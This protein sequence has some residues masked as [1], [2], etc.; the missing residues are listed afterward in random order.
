MAAINI[1]ASL[2]YDSSYTSKLVVRQSPNSSSSVIGSIDPGTSGIS[3]T[4]VDGLWYYVPDYGGWVYSSYLETEADITMVEKP[5]QQYTE[6][7]ANNILQS[8]ITSQETSQDEVSNLI[9]TSLEGIY[10]IPYQFMSSVDRKV[11]GTKLGTIYS[12][13]IVSR[14][15]LLLLS[16]G[17]VNFMRDYKSKNAAAQALQKL[18]ENSPLD[19]ANMLDSHGRYYTFDFDYVNYYKYVNAMC[20]SGAYFLNLQDTQVKIGGK[21]VKLKNADWGEAG[22]NAFKSI[23]SKREY[24]AFYVDSA[25]SVNEGFNNSTTE[26][27]LVSKIN[28][29]SDVG[30]EARFLMGN[31]TG[32]DLLSKFGGD[33]EAL[34]KANSMVDT[35][36]NEYLNGSKLFKD[37]ASNFATIA[38]GGKLIFPEIWSDSDYSKSYDINI[39]LRTPDGDKL[40]WF[41]NIYVP[42]AHLICMTAP[43][44]ASTKTTG[45]QAYSS[46]FLVRA[47]YKGLFNCDMGIITSLDITRGKEKSWTL[48]GLPTEVDVSM[49]IKDLYNVFALTSM[50]NPGAFVNNISLV[51][52]IANSCGVNMNEP[53]FTKML[54]VYMMLRG[55]RM[56]H[57]VSNAF[58]SIEEWLANKNMT[59]NDKLTNILSYRF[60]N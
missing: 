41:M 11:D 43:K 16:P 45:P 24:V 4:Q 35:I 33:A 26:S 12:D 60:F 7:E 49:T 28:S 47:F 5:L 36:T 37:I 39:K 54:Q 30:R 8:Y 46:P 44:E 38:V 42:L 23:Y 51:T 59:A 31:V 48:D 25:S 58:S 53:D 56:T 52:Y 32:A 15:P 2:T 3:A 50:D 9:T 14:M 57:I 21:W 29:L 18:I 10:G 19:L 17:K 1:T 34:E 6:S 27:Q 13:K 55:N 22:Q 40:S 20:V